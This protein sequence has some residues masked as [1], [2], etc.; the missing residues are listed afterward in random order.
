MPTAHDLHGINVRPLGGAGE[1]NVRYHPL[2]HECPICHAHAE[3]KILGSAFVGRHP[4]GCFELAVQCPRL[5][6][7]RLFVA[8]YEHTT[9]ES[10]I[11]DGYY[12]LQRT[13][14]TA[15]QAAPFPECIQSTSPTFVQ[16]YNQ[17]LAAEAHSL[18][19]LTGIGLRKAL[20]FLVKDFAVA[21]HAD[22]A[23]ATRKA[24]LSQCINK[25]GEDPN[26]KKCAA[27]AAWLGND[28][29]HYIRKWTDRDVGDLKLL[30]KL[31]VNWIE[32]VLLTENYEKAMPNGAKTATSTGSDHV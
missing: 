13:A 3:P 6:C 27:R 32:N 5:A 4:G 18:D 25:F 15:F 24:T 29:T 10:P 12:R 19:Q 2:P 26:V 28:E 21:K 23:E 8:T 17:A 9:V 7:G 20:E 1:I 14:P 22:Q 11:G 30:L 16:I 31:T